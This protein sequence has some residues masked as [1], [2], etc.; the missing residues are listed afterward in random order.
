MINTTWNKSDE[1][2]INFFAENGFSH[3]WDFSK[4]GE[5]WHEFFL[6][7]KM[8]CQLDFGVPLECLIEDL[9]CWKAGKEAT[10]SHDYILFCGENKKNLQILLN[11][12]N[13]P[14]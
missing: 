9:K 2:V 8:I 5:K 4:S 13:L 3:S 10:S 6:D 11:N 1:N 12:L 14:D 7:G